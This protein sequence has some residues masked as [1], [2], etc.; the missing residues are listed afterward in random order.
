MLKS[1]NIVIILVLMGLSC[2]Q[3]SWQNQ[4]WKVKVADIAKQNAHS[5]SKS[6]CGEYVR[7][8]IQRARGDKVQ[9]TGIK[10][11]KDFGP[12]LTSNG[13]A[14]TNKSF[15]DAKPGNIAIFEGNKA[16][17]HGHI[18]VLGRDNVWRS[19]FSQPS[20]IPW[21]DKKNNVPDAKIYE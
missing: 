3:K 15:K 4:N 6:K 9:G 10:S 7:E 14:E 5:K 11:S 1:L 13:Y 12:F 19:D 17:P 2:C 21:R 8:A 16:H 18:Q 20:H